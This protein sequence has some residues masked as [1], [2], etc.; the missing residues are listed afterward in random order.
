MDLIGD[1]LAGNQALDLS[2]REPP[3]IVCV[4]LAQ[5]P[6]TARQERRLSER[7]GLMQFASDAPFI[8]GGQL[9]VS[10]WAATIQA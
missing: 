10:L 4:G 6:L 8:A 2:S 3:V 7:E 5:T 9:C 1:H